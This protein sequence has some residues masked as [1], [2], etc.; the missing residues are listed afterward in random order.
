MKNKISVICVIFSLLMMLVAPGNSRIIGLAEED[1]TEYDGNLRIEDG[2]LRP[3][4]DYSDLRDPEYTNEDNDI[5]RF[6]V[7]VETDHD[8]DNDGMADLVKVFVQVPT[9]AVDGK[10]KAGVIYDPTPYGAGIVNQFYTSPDD[11]LLEKP[12]D[13]KTLYNSGKKRKASGEMSTKEAA[14]AARPDKDW[15]YAV[16]DSGGEGFTYGKYYDYYLVRGF[17]VVECSGIG[18]YGSEGFELCG[19]DLER[20]SH[21]CVVEWLTGDRIAYTDTTSNIQIKAD[22]SNG[23]VAM[24]G[25]SY[26][27]TLPYE[28]ATTGVK[29]L[30]TIIPYAGIASWYDYTNSQ[31]I[32]ITSD[33]E[34][35]N[36]LAA[37]TCGGVFLDD[38]WTVLNDEYRSWLWQISEDE[39]EANGNY[40]PIWEECDYSDDYQKINCS[41][42]IIQGLNDF[43]V[44]SKQANLMYNAF[45]KANKPVKLFLHQDGHNYLHTL[46]IDDEPWLEIQNKWLSHYLYDVDNGIEDM[47]EITVQ[48]NITGKFARYDS[49]GEY[50]EGKVSAVKTGDVTEVSSVGLAEY[51]EEASK[52]NTLIIDMQDDFYLGLDDRNAAVYDIE[53]PDEATISGVPEVHVRLSTNSVDLES[54]MITA[55]LIDTTDDGEPFHAYITK[56]K[57]SDT[58]P[59]KTVKELDQGGGLDPALLKDYV[60]SSTHAKC[61]SFGWTDL[62][63]P[64]CGSDQSEYT[65]TEKL[66]SGKYYDYTFYM[67]PTVYT[68]AKGHQLKL[69]LTTWDPYRVILDDTW[70]LDASL[71][72]EQ[73]EHTYSYVIDNSSVDVRLPLVKE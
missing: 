66:E 26:G 4:L 68:V 73:K 17:A 32:S 36:T 18:T 33:P 20:D 21:K 48:N 70:G 47:S 12:F 49:F 31:G 54:M 63:N 57:L 58:L 23:K 71:L 8:T 30:E 27:A 43:N 13:Y 42:L 53:L 1:S 29:G 2:M 28:V 59:V 67:L 11:A 72:E 69:I 39:T 3:M 61:F 55:I 41:A 56:S 37:F 62:T 22:W 15:N 9:G 44:T 46:V 16:P 52:N 65:K 45:K 7:Y 51:S 19:R 60:Q 34:Y 25:C 64:G 14:E 38:D 35:T 10:F 50:Q 6:C 5:Q 24:T 40:A